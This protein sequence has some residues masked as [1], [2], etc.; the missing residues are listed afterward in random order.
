[1]RL[2]SSS[3]QSLTEQSEL[4]AGGEAR[5]ITV[6]EQPSWAVKLFHQPTAER[7]AKVR[8]MLARRPAATRGL[9]WPVELVLDRSSN[10]FVGY[11]MPRIGG[12]RKAISFYNPSER[13][14]YSPAF[15]YQYLVRSARN[16]WTAAH[17][18]HQAGHIIGD[19]NES[20]I[21]I[22]DDATL[23]LV[24]TDSFQ[25]DGGTGQHFRCLVGKPEYT[26]P[27]LQGVDF[28][29]TSRDVYADCFGLA[30]I[31]FQ[32]LMEGVHPYAG[33]WSQG[34]PPS[35][36]DKIRH[37]LSPLNPRSPQGVPPS[38]PP[39]ALLAAPLRAL[40]VRTFADGTADRTRRPLPDE[41]IRELKD[42]EASLQGCNRMP[43]H[44]YPSHLRTC[45]WC[46]RAAKT[47]DSFPGG[48]RGQRAAVGPLTTLP[49]AVVSSSGP[50]VG[51]RTP[52]PRRQATPSLARLYVVLAVVA[53]A[54]AMAA[55]WGIGQ[56]RQGATHSASKTAKTEEKPERRATPDPLPPSPVPIEEATQRE[57]ARDEPRP[58]EEAPP[59]RPTP[60]VPRLKGT[61]GRVEL[62]SAEAT[63][64]L[65]ERPLIGAPLITELPNGEPVGIL[66]EQ[67]SE[68]G[69]RWAYVEALSKTERITGWTVR[70]L[71][72]PK[73]SDRER[74]CES[75]QY[76]EG[77]G[78]KPKPPPPVPDADEPATAALVALDRMNRC[79]NEQDEACYFGSFKDPL[80]CFYNKAYAPLTRVRESRQ[81]QFDGSA[82]PKFIDWPT[83]KV[84]A[85][86]ADRVVLGVGSKLVVMAKSHGAWLVVVEASA[87]HHACYPDFDRFADELAP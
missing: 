18:V 56:L 58:T 61:P 76:V 52:L 5:V 48:R 3:G 82:P 15:T 4:G 2:L 7:L 17:Q 46:E 33:I 59:S 50:T 21:L 86:S 62:S 63:A 39:H 55:V 27:E 73:L 77:Y 57:V 81:K 20:N 72:S 54:I 6:G 22:A 43:S 85:A 13:V 69:Y 10:R 51:I 25:V 9:A 60:V 87:K 44:V 30:V 1:M 78:C 71:L 42:F 80:D 24:D 45:P 74:C 47:F 14:K 26:P 79:Y 66:Q 35:T 38:S 12:A 75:H 16:L 19:V 68:D 65:R 53:I 28:K 11:A 84:L 8:A 34:A 49:P 70:Y 67:C 29:H 40:F 83:T 31:S 32:L 37:G 41:W 36:P 23:T 64:A